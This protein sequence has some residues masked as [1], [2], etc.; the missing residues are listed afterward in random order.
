MNKKKK[1]D[2]IKQTN[3]FFFKIS[4]DK[5]KD[6][7]TWIMNFSKF[8]IYNQAREDFWIIME[9]E[10]YKQEDMMARM[11][12]RFKLTDDLLKLREKL[13]KENNEKPYFVFSR[14]EIDILAK[15]QPKNK[16]ELLKIESIDRKKIEKYG[17]IFLE[18]I[19]EEY[20]W[21]IK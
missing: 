3:R 19:N 16:E 13:S 11:R 21:E 2:L 18:K 10:R 7:A 5:I 8:P 9:N 20:K 6:T 4:N 17:D 15:E 12:Y 14:K 1:E